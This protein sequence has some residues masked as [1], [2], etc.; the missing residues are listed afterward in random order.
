MDTTGWKFQLGDRVQKIKGSGWHGIVCGFYINPPL[1]ERGYN[2]RS[3]REE[4]SV[5][6]YP[7]SALESLTD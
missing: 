2:V 5:Q 6:L 7:E 3:E 1:T 4:N